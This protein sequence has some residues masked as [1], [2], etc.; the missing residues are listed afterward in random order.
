M[1]ALVAG[2]GGG[3]GAATTQQNNKENIKPGDDK[4][5]KKPARD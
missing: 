1:N 3:T 2:K 5:D 4:K